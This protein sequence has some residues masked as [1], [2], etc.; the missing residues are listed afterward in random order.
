VPFY[1]FRLTKR[2]TMC[3]DSIDKYFFTSHNRHSQTDISDR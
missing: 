3:Y 1:V 2:I